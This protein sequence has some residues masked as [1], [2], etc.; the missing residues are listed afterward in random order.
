M[1]LHSACT[2][3]TGGVCGGPFIEVGY[4][5]IVVPCLWEQK[6]FIDKGGPEILL[7]LG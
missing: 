4:A 5:E 1:R 7:A 6:T 3:S 2:Y